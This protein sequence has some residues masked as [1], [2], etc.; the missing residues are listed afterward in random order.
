MLHVLVAT[1]RTQQARELPQ[2]GVRSHTFPRTRAE[3]LIFFSVGEV[4]VVCALCRFIICCRLVF[5]TI[6]SPSPCEEVG[7]AQAKPVGRKQER[8]GAGDCEN[9]APD[10]APQRAQPRPP[11]YPTDT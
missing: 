9:A 3:V 7:A 8:L 1:R 4:G 2:V 11:A 10:R 5:S 6:A